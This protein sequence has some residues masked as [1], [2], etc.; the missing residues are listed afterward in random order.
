M[1]LI[2]RMTAVSVVLP[3]VADVSDRPYDCGLCGPS[4]LLLM[5][6]IDRMTAVSVDVKSNV[7]SFLLSLTSLTDHMTAVSVDVKSNVTSLLSSLTGP[8]CPGLQQHAMP[9]SALLPRR[10][11]TV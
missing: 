11:V 8:V 3:L 1:S 7:P 5:S 10:T 9:G 2:D 4:L 6:L